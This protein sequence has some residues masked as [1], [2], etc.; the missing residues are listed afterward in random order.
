M[1][2]L[3]KVRDAIIDWLFAKGEAIFDKLE[4]DSVEL[5]RL[6]P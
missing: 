1:K 3:A 4:A 6:E 5:D 2:L